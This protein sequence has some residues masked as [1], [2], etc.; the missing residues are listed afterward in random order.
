ME[1]ELIHADAAGLEVGRKLHT[2]CLAHFRSHWPQVESI[3][4]T[5]MYRSALRARMPTSAFKLSQ[6]QVSPKT[7]PQRSTATPKVTGASPHV[8]K[9][10]PNNMGSMGRIYADLQKETA[11]LA[12][13]QK[14]S[15]K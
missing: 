7:P 4:L 6:S 14:D 13:Q 9:A 3:T 15:L 1:L 8:A 5:H 10:S 12:S 2:R 11:A